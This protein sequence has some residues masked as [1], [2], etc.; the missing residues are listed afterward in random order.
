MRGP[1]TRNFGVCYKDF[2][3]QG[4]RSIFYPYSPVGN[5]STFD[6]KVT[7]SK[8]TSDVYFRETLARASLKTRIPGSPGNE[9]ERVGQCTDV[10]GPDAPNIPP[11]AGGKSVSPFGLDILH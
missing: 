6:V 8:L 3:G 10:Y 4:N 9:T 1:L 7:G 2:A 5:T 11:F